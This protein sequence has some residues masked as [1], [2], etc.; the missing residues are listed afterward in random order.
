MS[1]SVDET[2]GPGDTLACMSETS[3]RLPFLNA[4]MQGL[5]TSIFSE[6]TALAN[7]HGA[8]N[9]GQGFPDFDGP[10][11][12]KEAAIAAIRA[13]HNQ[14]VRS[15]GLPELCAAVAEHRRRFYG[16]EL[17]PLEE[18]TVMHGATEAIASTLLAVLEVG[19]EV[20]MFEPYYDSYRAITALAGAVPKI[21]PLRDPDFSFDP[22]ALVAAVGPKTRAILV[23]TPHNPT[24]KVFAHHE[25][26]L[27]ADL[28]I[29]HDLIAI[30]D[31]VYEHLVFAG[32]HRPLIG[33]PGM[34]DR[35]VMISSTGKTFSF[36]GWKIGYTCA[37]R[38]LTQAVRATH[39][40]ITFCNGTP[41]QHAMAQALRLPDAYFDAFLADYRTRRDR[42]CEG[43][44]SVG[45]RVLVPSGTYF[46]CVDIRPLGF[47][48]DREFCRLL[49]EKVGVAA[50]PNSAFYEDPAR[51]RHLVR[52][53]F[54]KSDPVLA[55]GIERL[56]QN[57]GK[58]HA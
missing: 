39:Q 55:A 28:C 57:I 6:I 36:T 33:Y 15:F 21:V 13:G 47:E 25:L 51:G 12:L 40:F 8:V 26:E 43:L 53:A 41:F 4:R 18:V 44:D 9:L 10:S 56:T 23:N 42:L 5:G 16:L 54:C 14:Y 2:S 35:T 3:V 27:I 49:P 52:F 20:V 30:T 1:T 38:A 32:E 19:D 45:F 11:E 22:A 46:V 7:A 24:G 48:D 37:G 58:L 31:E 29:R 34:R 17:D 50:I